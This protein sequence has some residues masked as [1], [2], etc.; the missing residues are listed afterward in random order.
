MVWN[1]ELF[2]IVGFAQLFSNGGKVSIIFQGQ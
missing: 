1:F 2:V